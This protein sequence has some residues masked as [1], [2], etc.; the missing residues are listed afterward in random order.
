MNSQ[1]KVLTCCISLAL[2]ACGGGGGG[3]SNSSNPAPVT[4]EPKEML[5]DGS[6]VAYSFKFQA[7]PA[8]QELK[9]VTQEIYAKDG[10]LYR[11]SS[12][13]P[14][15]DDYLLTDEAL[16]IP[17]TA[18][19]YDPAKGVRTDFLKIK[20]PLAWQATQYSQNGVRDLTRDIKWRAVNLADRTITV[21]IDPYTSAG[22]TIFGFK[23]GTTYNVL[24]LPAKVFA[25]QAKFSAQ[26]KCL[27][28]ESLK[29]SK[30]HYTFQ[31]DDASNAI[32]GLNTLAAWEQQQNG[33]APALRPLAA[34]QIKL[35]AGYK[36]GWLKFAVTGP[37]GSPLGAERVEYAIEYQGRLI[38]LKAE[39]VLNQSYTEGLD[40]AL[41]AWAGAYPQNLLDQIKANA[42]DTCSYYN[43]AAIDDIKQAI[44][45][46]KT[47]EAS[48]TRFIKDVPSIPETPVD[49]CWGNLTFC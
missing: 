36:T 13:A 32:S 46:A 33:L 49:N 18:A 42:A 28:M 34:L 5:F 19:S 8:T 12:D 23:P 14:K 1:F 21:A 15:F 9:P 7:D 16:Y 4:P 31:P 48:L 11:K 6:N 35:V 37:V 10:V 39:T 27:H 25:H 29:N 43:K 24:N 41:A 20:S 44:Q 17:E 30:V 47:T 2:T 22:V 40:K 45:Q 38:R 26:A 3:S